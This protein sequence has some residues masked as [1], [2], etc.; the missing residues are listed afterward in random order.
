MDNIRQAAARGAQCV[1]DGAKQAQAALKT[2]DVNALETALQTIT[3]G[4]R[5]IRSAMYLVAA[6][7]VRLPSEL[8]P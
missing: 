7:T 1:A 2:L 3:T 4:E 8:A 5:L 6:D